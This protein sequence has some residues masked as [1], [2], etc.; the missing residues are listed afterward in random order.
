MKVAK[1]FHLIDKPTFLGALGLLLAVTI[2]LMLYP[3][4]GAR[5]V[6]DAK[7]FLT[8]N[9]GFLYLLLGA[10]AGIFML[11]I[12][13]SDIGRISLG[14]PDEKPEFS[15]LS[16]AAMLFCAGIGAS[17]LYW[18]TIEWAYYYEA[19]P[20]SVTP[21]STEA[22]EWATAY[23]IFHWGITGW[24]LYCLPTLAIAYGYFVRGLP[25]LR[26]SANCRPVIGDAA[27]GWL[28]RLIDLIFMVGLLGAAGTGIGLAV[29][30]ISTGLSRLFGVEDT[31]GLNIA[32]IVAVTATFSASVW[33]GLEK[34]IQ[35][36][37]RWNIILTL[38]LLAFVLIVG[39]TVFILDT[40]TNALGQMLQNFIKMNFWTDPIDETGFV[41]SWTIFYWA[42]WIALAPFMGMFVARISKGRTLREVVIGMIGIGPAGCLIFFTILGNYALKLELDGA[43]SVTSQLQTEGAPYAI[44]SVILSLPAGVAALALFCLVSLVYMATTYD[45][46]AY[47]LALGATRRLAMGDHP[48]RWHRLFW[49]VVVGIIPLALMYLGGLKAFQT[50]SIAV[51]LPLVA[52][53]VLLAVALVKSLRADHLRR[54]GTADEFPPS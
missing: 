45:S 38:L 15:T 9:F 3:E 21:R 43:L 16:W 11:Y 47:T 13:F 33:Y 20:F 31:F 53:G 52:V 37:S 25:S 5:V 6:L 14:H 36:L 34:G 35:R 8:E 51:S 7:D 27:D 22:I 40:G 23:P 41:E 28:G 44:T 30:L 2:P 46:A 10:G 19:P 26:L 4:Q 42:W 50:A 17:I 24:A 48:P 54:S 29:P 18:G 32:V 1:S 39:P 12:A 49:A